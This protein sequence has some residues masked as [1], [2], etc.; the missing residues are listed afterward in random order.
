[1]EKIRWSS[2]SLRPLRGRIDQLVRIVDTLDASA[3]SRRCKI[4]LL[5][6][7]PGSGKSRLLLESMLLADRRGFA[8]IDGLPDRPRTMTPSATR[9]N[10]LESQIKDLLLRG[11]VLVVID[12]LHWV[13]TPSVEALLHLVDRFAGVPLVWE[14]ALRPG[15][16]DDLNGHFIKTI[17]RDGRA[18]RLQPLGA[19]PEP[20]IVEVIR[21]LLAA[22]P[23]QDLVG[24]C[25]CFDALPQVVVQL[26]QGLNEDGAIE[27]NDGI[28]KLLMDKSDSMASETVPA[29]ACL[30][31]LVSD[32]LSQLRS[33][34][35][36]SLQ[37]AAVLGRVFSPQDLS[38]MLG[39]AP[40]ELL[41]PLS[42][43]VATGAVVTQAADFAF[44]HD[45]IRRAVLG[46]VPAPLVPL[47][48][49]Q[50]AAMLVER[51]G[52]H[53]ERSAV[54]LLH[55]QA[56]DAEAVGIISRIAERLLTVAPDSAAAL[57]LRGME[58]APNGSRARLTMAGTAVVGLLRS[59]SL[60][61]SAEIA[62]EI[63]RNPCTVAGVLVDRVRATL[64]TV[65]A[66]RGEMDR[67]LFLVS[68]PGRFSQERAVR[69]TELTRLAVSS[70]SHIETAEK[71]AKTILADS[72][73]PPASVTMAAKSLLAT[74]S[75]RRGKVDDA[76]RA[77]EEAAYWWQRQSGD[78]FA[79]YPLWQKA[80]MLM[81]VQELDAADSVI[82]LL[83]RVI[84]SS[85]TEVLVP[86]HLSLRGWCRL[87]SGDLAGAEADGADAL[88]LCHRY[89][90]RLPVQWLHVLLGWTALH[91]GELASAAAHVQCLDECL[92]HDQQHPLWALRCL[93]CA[94]VAAASGEPG[95]ALRALQDAGGSLE[96]MI[97]DPASAVWCVRLA[98]D[99]GHEAFAW[100]VVR[101]AETMSE[102]NPDKPFFKAIAA[103]CRALMDR[104]PSTIKSI[105][106]QYVAPWVRASA[107]EDVGVLLCESDRAT[108]VSEL[109][110]AMAEYA[111]LGADWDAARVRHRLRDLGVRRRHWS[112]TTR[113]ATGWASLTVTE[114][115]VARLAA[116][117]LTNRQI[118]R[119]LFVS[120]HTV[121]FHLR[122]IYR[123]L[124][125]RSR[126]DLARIAP[127]QI[128]DASG[129]EQRDN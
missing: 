54:H 83:A 16:L 120:A 77:I 102:T 24:L 51:N 86:V 117:G 35:R 122:Q 96:L 95:M 46:T 63:M 3:K 55:A 8:V 6:S 113:A 106:A 129:P 23:S 29:P 123:K 42:E 28:A 61:R 9:A 32:R 26:V 66:L 103:H 119:E 1:M 25:E 38:E 84:E 4:L 99:R 43:A 126:V 75:W 67:A 92:Q 121:G 21:D 53:T 94:R 37:V 105:A 39:C 7:P 18:E 20:V 49:R 93:V 27:I 31:S 87:A 101:T 108:A 127:P 88:N 115:K 76:L 12:D 80:W 36:E 41:A 34:S 62:E 100:D 91:R 73:R 124:E 22:E 118:A 11:P 10:L 78:A 13:D 2:K 68:K 69:S 56:T 57:A 40:A 30:A 90:M 19:L 47:L 111:A 59:G 45:L 64:A 33:A 128:C 5:E 81:R 60:V 79:S 74:S 98:R 109:S 82:G 104:D 15:G 112:H 48:H 71:T 52:G 14:F 58:M 72:S 44:P 85:R 50:A 70:F 116:G 97:A 107:I 125:I 114:E 89:R 65:M 110:T 17:C